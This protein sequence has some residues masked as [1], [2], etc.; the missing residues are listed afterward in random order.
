MTD[1]T[2]APALSNRMADLAERAG[3]EARA[4]KRGSI[5]AHAAYLRAGA[6]LAEARAEARRGE[7]AAV[8]ARA[9]IESRSARNMM[10]LAKAGFTGET[11]HEAGGV[12]SALESLRADEKP[13]TVSVISPEPAKPADR[14][15]ALRERRK[16]AGL[17][18]D[19]GQPSD[20]KARCERC[21]S[22]QSK[23]ERQSRAGARRDGV[24]WPRL[25]EAAQ[26]RTGL[27]ARDV[28][29]LVAEGRDA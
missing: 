1:T 18:V 7:W 2:T 4:Y 22:R 11:L 19:C 5:E 3:E 17:C 28:A 29:A 27:S 10:T 20:G 13:E 8:L 6:I 14:R 25:I 16:A 26:L 12:R 24:T 15:K 23:G 9:G 21:R